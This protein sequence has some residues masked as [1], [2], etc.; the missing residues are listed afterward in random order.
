M[1]GLARLLLRRTIHNPVLNATVT[2]LRTSADS[3]GAITELE[4]TVMSGAGNPPHF[5]RTYDEAFTVLEGVIRIKLANGVRVDLSH[6]DSYVVKA[7]QV[8]SFHNGTDAPA[9]IRTQ[10]S[11]GNEGF[12]HALRIM[13]GLASDGLYN[14]RKMPR[15]L[16]HL[17]ICAAMSDTS[18]P[19]LL[20][21]LNLPLH[22]IARFARWRGVEENL[23]RTY[24]V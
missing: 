23:R 5:H 17:A 3:G 24:C 18:L 12:E 15:S 13:C 22:I 10:I 7:G 11:P 19:G 8:H 1:G 21:F 14:Q 2:F 4:T 6:G 20:S 9:R 16:Q